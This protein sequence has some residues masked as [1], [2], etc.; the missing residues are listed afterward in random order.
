MLR[1]EEPE[2]FHS[3]IPVL[4]LAASLLMIKHEQAQAQEFWS[5]TFLME[6]YTG[7]SRSS[8]AKELSKGGY[9]LSGGE[10]IDFR[11]WYAPKFRDTT[12]LFLKQLSPDF[13]I[14]FGA[15]TGE[16]GEKYKIDPALQLGFIYQYEP[17]E[18]ATVSIKA[19]YPIFGRFR[20]KP[21]T[22]DYGD[23][24][25]IQIVNCRL[26]ADIIPPQET[27]LYLVNTK[28]EIDAKISIN[29]TFVF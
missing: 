6:V 28:S 10:F 1:A 8:V 27:L 20:E 12:V 15:S 3:F 25:G 7:S 4:L 24:D 21:C 26:A 29:F 18:N 5:N 9:E 16:R 14:I 22:A 13:G 17:F 11:Q 2:M 23:L 19:I